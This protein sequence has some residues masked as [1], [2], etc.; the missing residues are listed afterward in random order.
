MPFDTCE[1]TV[2][3]DRMTGSIQPKGAWKRPRLSSCGV[4]RRS[5]RARRPPAQEG[6]QVGGHRR[7]KVIS[8]LTITAPAG[9]T[10]VPGRCR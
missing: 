9:K 10:A 8:T 4:G 1:L 3:A 2:G 7:V 5:E 6:L